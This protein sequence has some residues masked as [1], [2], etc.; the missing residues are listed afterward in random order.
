MRDVEGM[1]VLVLVLALAVIHLGGVDG[2]LLEAL[3]IELSARVGS[4]RAIT[5]N[6]G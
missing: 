3:E 1:A 4:A 5:S 2:A 6:W